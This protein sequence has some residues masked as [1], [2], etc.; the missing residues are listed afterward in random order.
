[1]RVLEL[2]PPVMQDFDALDFQCISTLCKH[3][4]KKG[5]TFPKKSSENQ[6][7]FFVYP[8]LYVI[9]LIVAQ[10]S[11]C[12]CQDA[13]MAL[14][15]YINMHWLHCTSTSFINLSFDKQ[16]ISWTPLAVFGYL[17]GHLPLIVPGEGE[18]QPCIWMSQSLEA[19]V[20][21]GFGITIVLSCYLF[22]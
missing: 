12:I 20:G 15:I 4:I 17:V 14:W 9:S 16:T 19:T 2:T 7:T 3:K 22:V 10:V 6:R 13:G 11:C 21:V 8:L 5:V 1:M 18:H